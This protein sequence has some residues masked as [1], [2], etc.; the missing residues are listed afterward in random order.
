MKN[1]FI[2]FTGTIHTHCSQSSHAATIYEYSAIYSAIS[3]KP[4]SGLKALRSP[5]HRRVC[6]DL[7][8]VSRII[9]LELNQGLVGILNWCAF[10]DSTS[11]AK[12]VRDD[13]RFVTERFVMDRRTE[14]R[15]DG[16]TD[17][18]RAFLL[19]PAGATGG[20]KAIFCAVH[21]LQI[22]PCRRY[23]SNEF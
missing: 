12:E 22:Y 9:V 11:K 17:G 7:E 6:C 21:S 14:S 10:G 13:I 3:N 18:W 23:Q 4:G 2:S 20:Q 16:K 5:P 8:N 19:F 15:K 1:V